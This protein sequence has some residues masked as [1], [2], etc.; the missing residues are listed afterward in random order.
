MSKFSIIVPA[1]N[2]QEHIKPLMESIR[3]QTFRDY[4]LIVVCDSCTDNTEQ[5]AKSYGAITDN[6]S[7][8]SDGLTR[9]RGLD[10][11]TGDWILFADDDDWFYSADA[12]QKLADFID[13]QSPS[14][15]VIGFG[16]KTRV[17]GFVHPSYESIFTPRIAHVWSS[18]WRRASIGNAHFGDAVFCSDTY[19]INAIKTKGAQYKLFDEILYYYNFLRPGSQTDLFCRGIIKESPIAQ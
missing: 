2:A 1:Y 14:V 15:D 9:D 6:V 10:I 19:F 8:H 17:K 11:A 16:Y 3:E 18:C 7:F 4:E 13:K 5:I 12:F